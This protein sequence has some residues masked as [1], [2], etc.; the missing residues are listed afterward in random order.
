MRLPPTVR[1]LVLALVLTAWLAG[2]SVKAPPAPAQQ[3]TATQPAPLPAQG[4][5][6]AEPNPESPE[7]AEAVKV[8][9]EET[10]AWLMPSHYRRYR[11][12]VRDAGMAESQAVTEELIRTGDGLVATYNGKAYVHWVIDETGVWRL[13][14]KGGGALLRYL[15]PTLKRDLYWQQTSGDAVVYFGLTTGGDAC[16]NVRSSGPC[17]SLRVLNRSELTEFAFAAGG[18]PLSVIHKDVRNPAGSFRK[19]Y[20][21]SLEGTPSQSDRERFLLEAPP[22]T[23]TRAPVT[24]ITAQAFREALSKLP[25]LVADLDGDGKPED[26][27]AQDN[28]L[29]IIGAEGQ[30]QVEP[31]W[32]EI[33]TEQDGV[34]AERIDL[35]QS[36]PLVRL[37]RKYYCFKGGPA[38]VFLWYDTKSK[39]YQFTPEPLCQVYTY[40][41]NGL[42]EVDGGNGT[43]LYYTDK[44]RWQDGQ[45]VRQERVQSLVL[46]W[47]R[48]ERL[49]WVLT[50]VANETVEAESRL[51]ASPEVEQAFQSRLDPGTWAFT[52]PEISDR[53]IRFK[54]SLNGQPRGYLTVEVGPPVDNEDRYDPETI[55]I[56]KLTWS[57]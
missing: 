41:G 35:P 4:P 29:V 7:P 37:E 18:G 27:L 1:P 28:H 52:D 19:W 9:R 36:P 42:F 23:G 5:A 22:G 49:A 20:V 47:V 13:D 16:L 51:F 17:W 54:A 24:E 26:L 34:E 3:Q 39:Q 57:D 48:P 38:S 53:Q 55:Q 12:E 11:Y 46:R 40:N 21:E 32:L 10:G 31:P 14:P 43:P 50:E 56:H 2:C 8:P 44:V 6:P 45:F 33:L 25:L 30:T 15:P